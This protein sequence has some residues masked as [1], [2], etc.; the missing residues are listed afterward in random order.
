MKTNL[1][2]T[3]LLATAALVSSCDKDDDSIPVDQTIESAFKSQYPDITRVGW[4][5]K[6]GYYVAEFRVNGLEAEAWY[7]S[8]GVWYM[9]ETDVRYADMPQAVKSTFEASEYATWRIDDID[10]Y[11][12]TTNEFYLLELESGN[13]EVHLKI[14]P[15]GNILP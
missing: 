3:M 8:E 2:I 4:E 7:T 12:T 15:E 10:H 9:T 14:D 13:R 6:A 11:K 5:M 1:F